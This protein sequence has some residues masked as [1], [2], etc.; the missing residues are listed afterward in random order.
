MNRERT[1][2]E[3]EICEQ[4]DKWHALLLRQDARETVRLLMNFWLD[5]TY[6]VNF[7]VG[8]PV[9]PSGIFQAPSC[10]KRLKFS[11]QLLTVQR[12]S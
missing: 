9:S 6:C 2:G 11:Q 1:M 7:H 3:L 10:E 8:V 12:S 4:W 5:V